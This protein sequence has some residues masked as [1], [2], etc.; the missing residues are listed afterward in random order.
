MRNVNECTTFLRN[1]FLKKEKEKSSSK[2]TRK[3]PTQKAE[4]MSC[5]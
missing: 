4:K 2:E 3:E 1:S 5:K